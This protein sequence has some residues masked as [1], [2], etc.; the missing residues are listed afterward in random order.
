MPTGIYR[1]TKSSM[2]YVEEH[3][4]VDL[5]ERVEEC[6]GKCNRGR[7]APTGKPLEYRVDIGMMKVERMMRIKEYLS[8]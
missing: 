6:K 2:N 5:D 4:E 7:N 8:T 3:I 1:T